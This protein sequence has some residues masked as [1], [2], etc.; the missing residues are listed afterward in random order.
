[1]ALLATCRVPL[2]LPSACGSKITV[3]V[4]EA[5]AATETGAAVPTWKSGLAGVME[6][7]MP[8]RGALPALVIVT[9]T[10]D[11]APRLVPGKM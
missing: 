2:R 1:M 11:S 7:A 10:D 4:A 5:P 8:V 6:A 9:V 3:K